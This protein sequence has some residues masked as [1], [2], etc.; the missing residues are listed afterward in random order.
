M[1]LFCELDEVFSR[2]V[3]PSPRLEQ[4]TNSEDQKDDLQQRPARVILV[5]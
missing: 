2:I 3:C 1:H 5:G 4:G